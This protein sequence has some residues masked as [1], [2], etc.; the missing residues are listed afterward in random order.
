MRRPRIGRPKS[1]KGTTKGSV[2]TVRLQKQERVALRNASAK[3]GMRLS[4]WVRNILLAAATTNRIRSAETEAAGIEP[5]PATYTDGGP[6]GVK[7]R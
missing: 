3:A 1:P 2:I 4:Q 5:H 7:P 6:E